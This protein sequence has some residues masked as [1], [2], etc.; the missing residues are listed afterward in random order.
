MRADRDP[1]ILGYVRTPFG[2]AGKGCFREVRSDDLGAHV[3]RALLERTG[4]DPTQVE[5]VVM[6][7]VEQFGEQAHPGRNVAVLAGLPF[8]VAGLSIERACATAMSAIHYAAMA[9]RY[10]AGDLFI[11]GGM[12]SMSHFSLPVVTPETDLQALLEEK[13][14]MLSMMVPNPRIFERMNPIEAVGGVTAEKL[15]SLYGIGREQ[16]DRWAL[17]S[18]ERAV[19]AQREGRF[20]LEIAPLE[21]ILPDGNRGIVTEDEWPRP[22]LSWERVRELPTPFKPQGGTVSSAS[23]SKSADGAAAVLLASREWARRFGLEPL[24]TVRSVGVVGV[25]PTIM[26]Y[27]NVPASLK[28]LKRAGLEPGDVDLWE[29]NEAFAVV[30]LV[31]MKELGLDPERVNV[32]GGACALGHPVGASGA[33]LVGTLALELKRRGLRW[34]V[35]SICAGYGQG[36]ATVLEREE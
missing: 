19:R 8:E 23:A 36:A 34:G 3:V 30:V 9:I 32:N 21:G 13:G 28:A 22:D 14:T 33:R 5:E 24:A 2:K 25:D 27:A 17:L 26:G 4:V 7:A 10:G 15:A 6:G 31:A 1:V 18:N 29:I 12:D 16:Q 35:A 11:A 20:A